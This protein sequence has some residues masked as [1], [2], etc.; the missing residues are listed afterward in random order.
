MV[1]LTSNFQDA[2]DIV[3]NA[4]PLPELT[5][6]GKMILP[7]VQQRPQPL[8][9]YQSQTPVLNNEQIQLL[10]KIQAKMPLTASEFNQAKQLQQFLQYQVRMRAQTQQPGQY[11]YAYYQQQGLFLTFH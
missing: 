2:F 11:P 7:A 9:A 10:R 1:K 5:Q 8:P 6:M 4:P 3:R